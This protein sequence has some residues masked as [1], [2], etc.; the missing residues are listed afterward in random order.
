[1]PLYEARQTA[2]RH[3]LVEAESPEEARQLAADTPLEA[4]VLPPA[5]G[6][7]VS[8]VVFGQFRGSRDPVSS[9]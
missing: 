9:L 5:V 2:T 7:T 6:L 1:M 3:L 4:W 8:P